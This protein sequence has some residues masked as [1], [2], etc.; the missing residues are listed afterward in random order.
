MCC[1]F[2]ADEGS[3]LRG[4]G[5]GLGLRYTEW[6]A[7]EFLVASE[8]KMDGGWWGRG[9]VKVVGKFP[10]RIKYEMDQAGCG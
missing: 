7:E 2:A 4:F 3:C 9:L 8:D 10:P 5:Y 1:R 6:L